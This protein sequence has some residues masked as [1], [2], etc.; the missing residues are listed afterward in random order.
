MAQFI[1]NYNA[2]LPASHRF[3]IHILDNTHMFVQPHVA[4]MIRNAI[5][6]FRDQISYEKPTWAMLLIEV[7]LY[8]CIFFFFFG[9]IDFASKIYCAF[10]QFYFVVMSL[11]YAMYIIWLEDLKWQRLV[12]FKVDTKFKIIYFSLKR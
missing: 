11:H 7:S 3:I 9:V 12:I 8:N 2:S 10:K 6:E 5:S 4:D 1:I